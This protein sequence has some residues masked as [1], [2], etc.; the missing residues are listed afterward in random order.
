M[1]RDRVNGVRLGEGTDEL[2]QPIILPVKEAEHHTHKLRILNEWLLGPVDG[3]MW[4]QLLQRAWGSHTV[5][6]MKHRSS[7]SGVWILFK[8]NRRFHRYKICSH[9]VFYLL[10]VQVPLPPSSR[11]TFSLFPANGAAAP[12]QN[13]PLLPPPL[14]LQHGHLETELWLRCCT[15]V[16][17]VD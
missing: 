16:L 9:L 4:N 8:S 1:Y 11:G 7:Y 5:Q 13:Y 10:A 15:T 14:L 3:S 6:C 2:T 12:E 17:G